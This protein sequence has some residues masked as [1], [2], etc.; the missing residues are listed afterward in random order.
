MLKKLLFI[1]LVISIIVN[2]NNLS[3]ETTILVPLKKPSLTDEEIVKKLTQNILLPIKKPKKI[4]EIKIVEKKITKTVKDTKDKKLSFKIPKKKPSIPGV[5]TSRSV[6]I[7]KYYSKKDFNIAR[8]AISEMQKSRWTSSLKIAKK[9]K[10]K[11]IYNFIKWR[12]LL[13]T[14][15]QASFYDY[16][17]F[18]DRNNQYPRI[19]RLRYLAEHKLSTSKVSPKKIIK[20]FT[21]KDPL[22]GYGQMILGESF[23]LT[24][25]KTKGINLIKKG[26]ITAKISKNE[27][28]FFRKKFKKYL[29]ADDYI[30]RADYL[31]WNNKYWDLRRLTRY[32]PKDYE[33]L[34]TARH[35]LMSKG[36][37]VDQA[38]KNVPEKLKNDA[39]L[40][41]DRLKWRRKKGRVD[42]SVE[43]L[44]K[45]KN[46]KDYLVMPEKWWKEREII[47]RKLIYKK[48]YEIAYKITSEHG[49]TAGAEFAEAEWMSG[50][51]ALSFL[52]DPLIAK[53]HFHNFYKNVSYPI[54]TSRGAFWL[55]RTYEKLGNKEQSLKWYQKAS[56]YL[57]TYYGQLAFLK[58][59]P[60]GKFT[61]ND[62][63]EVD[64]KYRY[65]FYNK[66]LVKIIYLLDELKKDKYTKYILR[67][68]ANDNIKRG[69][70]ILAAELATSI[71]R[72]DFAIQVSKIASYQKRFHNQFNYP[73]I[74]TPKTINGRKIPES[75]FILSIIRQES[76]FDLSA[77]SHAG[78]KGLMQLMPYTAKL[79][80]KQAKLPY[81]K[82]RLTTDP[83]YNINLGSHY[84]AGLILQYDGAYPFATA[85]YN[86]GPNRVKYWKKINKDPQKKQV[87]YVDWVEL[88]KFRETRNYVQRVLENYNVYRYILEKKPIIMKNF[89][90]DQPLY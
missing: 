43:I 47:S 59:N 82:S 32:L 18:I 34:Y 41:Y 33:L 69:S 57:T 64:N 11:S 71:E 62:S 48:K 17:V 2:I 26:W 40:N 16:K 67:H 45:I 73:I 58:L 15:N 3:A 39:G 65:I 29:N 35:I 20:W 4:K 24:G 36:Y 79:V 14:G 6:K 86:A 89:F 56:K 61:L 75:A 87:D 77:N 70:E 74:S 10:D 38:I 81:S 78:A 88:I 83:E 8:K 42:S 55:G 80:S 46:D 9:A 23:I 76:E 12:Y 60:N 37:G 19:D 28:K 72:Y 25:E 30:K 31:A 50:W 51:I 5:T 68:L 44:M 7:S 85:A 54:S 52:N 53:D 27:L 84:I 49:M 66:E 13:T 21:G 63:M 90:K 1:S 22:S